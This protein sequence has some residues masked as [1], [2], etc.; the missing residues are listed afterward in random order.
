[1]IKNFNELNEMTQKCSACLSAKFTGADGKRHIVLCGGTGCLSSHSAEIMDEFNRLLKEKGLEDKAT[2]NQVG[3]FGFCSQGPF[4][5]IYPEDTLYRMVAIED[6]A[7]IVEK[8]I[9]GG[10]VVERLLYVDPVTGEK[11]SKQED[12]NFYKKQVRIALHGG[13]SLNPEKIEESLG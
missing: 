1:M 9:I 4:V 13:G 6:V 3:C 10:E 8:D 5:K 7:E 2:V 12:I 11:V